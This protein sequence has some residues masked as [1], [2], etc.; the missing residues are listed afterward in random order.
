MKDYLD[1]SF[2]ANPLYEYIKWLGIKIFYQCK[3]WGK[4][5]RIGYGSYVRRCIFGRYNIIGKNVLLVDCKVGN[6]SYLSDGCTIT[7][8]AIGKFCSIGPNVRCAP[9]RHPTSTFVSTH[10]LTF[11]SPSF[12]IKSFGATSLFEGNLKVT[13]GNDVW[14]G[15]NC[16]V[17]DG[18]I[19][20]DGA[21]IAANSVVTKNVEPYSIVGGLPAKLIRKR[22][23]DKNV[24]ALLSVK[25]WDKSDEW[26][27]EN[28]KKFQDV[29]TFIPVIEDDVF[30]R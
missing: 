7:N 8:T 22:F 24:S 11:G 23:S 30:H 12:L 15:A 14:V 5:L 1:T 16:V 10:P 17:I 29:D 19:I 25:W 6:F 28:I 13:I 18:V 2:L 26:L 27:F 21:I 3:Y 9:G 4:H 20:G